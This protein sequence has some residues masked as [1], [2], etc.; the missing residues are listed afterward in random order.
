MRGSSQPATSFPDQLEQAPLA[1]DGVA[2]VEAGELDLLGMVDAQLVEEPVVERAVDLELQ[3]ADGVGDALEGVALA[4]G[5]VVHRVDAPLVAG[6]G[7]RLVA[8]AV[9]DGVAQEDVGGGHVDLGPQGLRAVGELAGLHPGEEVEVLLDG[10]VAVGGRSA[11][12]GQRAAVLADL[13]GG[14]V[15]DEGPPLRMRMTAQS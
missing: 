14:Q 11:G 6:A 10:A 7:V 15:V 4:V 13:V 2:E 5:P 8:D 9:H 1:Q 3:G 12:P